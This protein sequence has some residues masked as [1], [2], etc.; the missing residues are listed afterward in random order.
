MK[1]QGNDALNKAN[2]LF[3]SMRT[4]PK[5]DSFSNIESRHLA[6]DGKFY[7]VLRENDK[8]VLKVQNTENPTL[9]E[10][11]DYINGVQNKSRYS[12]RGYNDIMKL[13]N[14]MDIEMKRT[15]GDSLMNEAKSVLKVK[16]K[17]LSQK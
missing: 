12:K 7:G 17:N 1:L 10:H 13:F 8:Y 5:V 11:F 15:Y 3:E 16:K 6:H 14:L 2:K 4:S 9:V